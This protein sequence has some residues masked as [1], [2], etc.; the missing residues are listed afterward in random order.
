MEFLQSLSQSPLFSW[1]SGQQL[2]YYSLLSGHAIGMGVVVGIVYMLCARV[3]GFTGVPLA[4]FDRL[5]QL[6]WAGFVLN[7]ITGLLLFAANGK[8][9]IEN[10]PFILKLTFIALGGVSLWGMSRALAAQP[11][12]TAQVGASPQARV[13]AVVTLLLWTAAIVCGRIIAYTISY[14]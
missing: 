10:T 9:L 14:I 3:L 7:L 4:I 1:V 11:A 13:L 8:H 6:A 5:Y 12:G 2:A